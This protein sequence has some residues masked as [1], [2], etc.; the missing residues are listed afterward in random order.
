MA[1]WSDNVSKTCQAALSF[2]PTGG[3]ATSVAS[4]TKLSEAGMLKLTVTDEAGNSANADIQLTRSD[5]K[6]PEI[7]LVVSEK[8]VIAGVTATLQ[9]GRLLFDEEVAATWTDDYSAAP[10]ASLTFQAEG[11]QTAVAVNSGDQLSQ[12]GTLKLTVTDE[13]EN[14]ASGEI[15]LT[16]VAVYGLD[17]LSSLNLQ[18]DKE[19]D[20]LAGLTVADGLTLTKVEIEQDGT[21]TELSAPYRYTPEFP[22][23]AAFILTLTKPSGEAVEVRAEALTI[24][25]LEYIVIALET[26]DV[27]N[28]QYAWFDNINET[29]QSFIYPHVLVSYLASERYREKD[30][31]Y[32][33]IA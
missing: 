3:S 15:T 27:I 28:S 21:R 20:L 5:T 18:V 10:E 1:T 31:E 30:N 9:E 26:A 2:T 17:A 29:T 14:A 8:N 23:T 25:P 6:A 24:K 19:S 7:N 12:A 4:G 33:I 11:S 13:F 22:G 16:A 32:R